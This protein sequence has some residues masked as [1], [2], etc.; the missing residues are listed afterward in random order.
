MKDR[1][2]CE[3][4]CGAFDERRSL[5]ELRIEAQLYGE[6]RVILQRFDL[7]GIRPFVHRR[8]EITRHPM[9]I[10]SQLF[11]LDDFLKLVDRGSSRIHAACA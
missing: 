6:A 4:H 1:L 11:G 7:V 2:I 3:T 10:T 9:E 8:V 5:H